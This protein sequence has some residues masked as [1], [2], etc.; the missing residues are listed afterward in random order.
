LRAEV[1][2]PFG[3]TNAASTAS[4]EP[5]RLSSLDDESGRHHLRPSNRR[6]ARWIE[7]HLSTKFVHAKEIM[8][9]KFVW[10][11]MFVGSAIGNML[12]TLWGGDAISLSGV[13]FALAGGVIGIWVGYRI[14][15]SM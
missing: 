14:G 9:K 13:M 15:Q 7:V 8:T 6:P 12:P 5:T 3:I 11:G 10:I 1:G 2:K 4:Y